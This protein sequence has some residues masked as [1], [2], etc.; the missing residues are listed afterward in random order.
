M[1]LLKIYQADEVGISG[2]DL[3]NELTVSFAGTWSAKSGTIYPLLSRLKDRKLIKSEEIR[4]K[5]GPV[6]KVFKITNISRN[7]IEELLIDSFEPDLKFLENY[8][9]FT[10]QMMQQ[11]MQKNTIDLITLEQILSALKLFSK[12]LDEMQRRLA[13]VIESKILKCQK[14]QGVIEPNM[15]FCPHCGSKIEK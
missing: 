9:E 10:L 13:A 8:L 4:S 5:L 3:M 6:K 14:C 11:L 12:H 7:I 1:I 15:K 2:Y